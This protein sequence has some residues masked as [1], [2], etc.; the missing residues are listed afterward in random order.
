MAE[1]LNATCSICGKKYH[2]CRS[3]NDIQS[4][5][6]WRTV[7]DTLPHYMIYLI[8]AEYTKTKDKVS[9]KKELEKCNLSELNTFDEDVK[10][11]IKEIMAENKLEET[12]P[13]SSQKITKLNVKKI[14]QNKKNDI[15]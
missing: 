3:C 13:V 5:Q 1:N 6:P 4:F 7:C 10:K 9:A 2:V 15:E 12:H 14:E 11:V 8:L